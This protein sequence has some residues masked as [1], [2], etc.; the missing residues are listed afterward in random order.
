M[1]VWEDVHLCV[2]AEQ[3]Q[4]NMQSCETILLIICSY[5]FI[6]SICNVDKCKETWFY[7]NLKRKR[8]PYVCLKVQL[9]ISQFST[10]DIIVTVQ[11]RL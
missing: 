11:C 1:Y 9:G 5:A 6:F 2:W 4:A 10:F 7:F 3:A 8:L